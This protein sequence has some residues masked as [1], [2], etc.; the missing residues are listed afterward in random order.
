MS[1]RFG[2][3]TFYGN[4]FIGFYARTNN[5][6]TLIGVSAP[7]K[8][9]RMSDLLGTKTIKTTFAESPLIGIY[10]VMN[11]N[12]IIIS[13][14]AEDWEVNLL[15][16]SLKEAGSD[17]NVLKMKTN[18]TALGNNIALNDSGALINPDFASD[19][20]AK[21]ISDVLQVDIE[22]RTIAGY[23]TVG[24]AVAATNKGF[25]AHPHITEEEMEALKSLF[26][27]DGGVGTA[28][29]GTPFVSLGIVANDKSV[30]FGDLTT[31][32]ELHR[33]EESLDLIR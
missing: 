7:D 6:T 15:K 11:S 2:K 14:V 1:D 4:P 10:C 9:T 28:N 5:D 24:A 29:G 25:I 8:F 18:F 16:K 22:A 17:I 19:S 21:E 3:F 32:F 13:E 20:I 26:K 27:V 12:G 23:K 30:V 31:G 33:I